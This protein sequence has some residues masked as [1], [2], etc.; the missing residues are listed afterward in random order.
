MATDVATVEQVVQ[1]SLLR[2]AKDHFCKLCKSDEIFGGVAKVGCE[3]EGEG[4]LTVSLSL[5]STDTG[6]SLC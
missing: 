4:R 2:N 1:L 6:L 5:L 3:C